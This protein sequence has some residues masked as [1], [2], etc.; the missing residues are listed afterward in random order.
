MV[1]PS[2]PPCW[3]AVTFSSFWRLLCGA[4]DQPSGKLT[5]RLVPL[6]WTL[7]F[8]GGSGCCAMAG[9]TVKSEA[10]QKSATVAVGNG[11]R[12]TREGNMVTSRRKRP[13]ESS[14][15]RKRNVTLQSLSN[16]QPPPKNASPGAT[17]NLNL[18]QKSRISKRPKWV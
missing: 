6:I 1:V 8:N 2:R 3:S 17:T 10:A 7:W 9:T 16:F 13:R 5:V 11:H 4:A 18:G 14:E 15:F 12:E